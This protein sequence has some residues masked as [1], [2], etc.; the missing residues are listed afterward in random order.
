M[1]R[2]S[3]STAPQPNGE[4]DASASSSIPVSIVLMA[5]W[6]GLA[7]GLLELA[8][9]II[10]V[11]V[12]ER[13]FFLRSRHF[14]WMVPVSDLAIFGSC[15][16]LLAAVGR[17]GRHPSPR[18]VIGGF[19]LL[20]CMSQFL[21]VRGLHSL[22][23]ALL[24]VG[25][26]VRASRWIAGRRASLWRLIHRSLPVLAV[27][28]A[29][30]VATAIVGDR[31]PRPRASNPPQGPNV[32]LIV[33]DTV[34]ADR[35]GLYGYR[36]DTTPNLARLAEQGVRFRRARST[37]PW[38]LPSHASLFTGRW[39]HELQVERLGRLD[40]GTPTLAEV[41]AARGFATGGFVA[42]TFFCGHES[43]LSR[44]FDTYRDHSVS[45]G[46]VFRSSSLGWFLARNLIRAREE[47]LW[48]ITAE[49]PA[50]IGLDFPRKSAAAVNR[51]FLDWLD[52]VREGPFFAFLNYFDAHDP[53]LPPERPARPFGA[54]PRSQEQFAMLRDWQKLDR[55]SLDS[56]S[57]SL[58]GDAYDDCIAAL[59]RELG[60]LFDD[61]RRR[62]VLDRTLLIV[63]ADHGEQFGEHGAFGHGM[64]LHEPEV[65]V[66][67]IVAFPGR[68]PRGAIVEEAVS[69]RDV[70][71]TVAAM[72]GGGDP[73]P[74]PGTP[75][76][77]TWNGS[78]PRDPESPDAPLSE[79]ETPIE[80]PPESSGPRRHHGPSK[81]ILAGSAAYLR[82]GDGTEELYD[83]DSDPAES[84]DLSPSAEAGPLLARCRRILGRLVGRSEPPRE[85]CDHSPP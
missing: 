7:A 49:G 75:L 50:Q 47:I 39:P 41:L 71:A 55:N 76:T 10:R 70:P 74:F 11:Q 84:R 4:T 51:E 9:L 72:V 42:N 52:G 81:S 46:E 1:T 19:L 18:L 83:L 64:S 60:R 34:R 17:L 32:V 8:S 2:L 37:A 48:A 68:V 25:I 85:A 40:A 43:G 80:G 44:G 45:P 6:F 56:T 35:L 63:T 79:L 69:L 36:R 33:L 5:T 38:T 28:L 14:V 22:T 62:D 77:R 82:H 12:L 3:G 16:L 21:L 31:S 66:P 78:P 27:I 59:D 29:I 65:H 26:A 23:C 13:G 54:A 20:A 15:G 67:L 58:A 61:L 24:S 30:L 53:Y 57:Q 73:S